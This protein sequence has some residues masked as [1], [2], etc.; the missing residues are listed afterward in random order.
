MHYVD[1]SHTM[2]NQMPIYPGDKTVEIVSKDCGSDVIGN[3]LHCSMHNGTHIDAPGHMVPGGKNIADVPVDAFVGSG[4]LLDVR[5]KKQISADAISGVTLVANSIVLIYTGYSDMFHSK[6]YFETYPPFT[7]DFA[8]ELI[9]AGV[10]MV[11]MDT[12][13]PDY[14]PFAIHKMLFRHN[15]LIIENLTHLDQ[16]LSKT[17]EV[18]AL[19]INIEADGAL[20][21]VIA[22]I[23]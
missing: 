15:I 3:T 23:S 16:L 7:E 12:P 9:K 21:R 14:A 2:K 20:A 19:P 17:F 18:I 13:S 10:K 8:Q 1:L 5:G 6:E 4:T 11:G 22:R